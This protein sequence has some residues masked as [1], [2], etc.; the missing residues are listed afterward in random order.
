MK[1]LLVS[2]LFAALALSAGAQKVNEQSLLNNV[3]KAEANLQDPKKNVKPAFWVAL[4]RANHEIATAN[5]K[6]LY[7]EMPVADMLMLLGQPTNASAVPVVTIE[8]ESF[9]KYVYPNI[10]V[11]LDENDKVAAFTE[12]K[13]LKADALAEEEAALRKALA[14]N[15]KSLEEDILTMMNGMITVYMSKGQNCYLLLDYSGSAENY[16]RAGMLQKDPMINEDS[17]NETLYFAAV[18]AI[19]G[20]NPK[21][22]EPILDVLMEDK[23]YKNGEVVYYTAV[24]KDQL[25]KKDEA[26]KIYLMG[27]ENYPEMNKILNALVS[28]Y[29]ANGEDPNKV[30]PYI[31]R[32]QEKDPNNAVLYIAEGLAYESLNDK[33]KALAAYMKA[34]DVKPDYFDALYNAGLTLYKRSST[35]AEELGAIDP[36]NKTEF[37]SKLK[38]VDDLQM[39]AMGLLERAHAAKPTDKNTVEV[40]KAIYFRFRDKSDEMKANYEKYNELFKTM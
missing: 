24:I 27:V 17:A 40:L 1:K 14:L 18:A 35:A 10:D 37:D 34:I 33:D 19:Q 22:A 32:A 15:P 23:F 38:E 5:L 20:L 26:E 39:E 30:I 21:L 3:K 29:I 2:I 16:Y 9:K 28:F 25:G 36:T 12:T 6:G 11:Y 13:V 8:G 31:T 4:A 7:I